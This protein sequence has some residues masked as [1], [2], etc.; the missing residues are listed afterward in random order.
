M[1]TYIYHV[2][3]VNSTASVLP[4]VSETGSWTHM[5]EI[6][7]ASHYVISLSTVIQLFCETRLEL[8]GHTDVIHNLLP[9]IMQYLKYTM[10]VVKLLS[11]A[12][13][14]QECL[15]LDQTYVCSMTQVSDIQHVTAASYIIF[16]RG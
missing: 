4:R 11:T 1:V 7:I 16:G 13:V 10:S 2:D 9:H 15:Q 14:L 5:Y 3:A 6:P 8:V 12:G